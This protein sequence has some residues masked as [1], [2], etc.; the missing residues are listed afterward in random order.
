[1][2]RR[3]FIKYEVSKG[4]S[5]VRILSVGI[6]PTEKNRFKLIDETP[7]IHLSVGVSPTEKG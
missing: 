2:E 5:G 4:Q 3:W 7:T 1:M 6:S